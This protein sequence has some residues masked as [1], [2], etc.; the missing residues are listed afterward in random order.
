MMKN[1]DKISILALSQ[2]LISSQDSHPYLWVPGRT[3]QSR[4]RAYPG[5]LA[6]RASHRNFPGN[7]RN[8]FL[9]LVAIFLVTFITLTAARLAGFNAWGDKKGIHDGRLVNCFL[10]RMDR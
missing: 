8:V 1:T 9:R 2:R 10:Y 7:E 6:E 3:W 5:T 4:S